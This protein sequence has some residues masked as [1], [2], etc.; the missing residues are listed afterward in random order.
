MPVAI[1][2]G[3][4]APNNDA[5]ITISNPLNKTL[6][7]TRDDYDT[8]QTVTLAADGDGDQIDGTRDI[9]HT[10]SG[11]NSGYAGDRAGLL[12]VCPPRSISA[13]PASVMATLGK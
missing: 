7:F 10:A 13:S 3:T 6:T 4:T 12:A 11:A 8:A 2:E 5:D 1:A 9:T